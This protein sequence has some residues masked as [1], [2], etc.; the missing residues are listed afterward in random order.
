MLETVKNDKFF[1][2][3]GLMQCFRIKERPIPLM[4]ENDSYF[5]EE[6]GTTQI[7]RSNILQNKV[8]KVYAGETRAVLLDAG[9]EVNG[10]PR[11]QFNGGSGSKV[12]ITYFEKFVNATKMIKKTDAENGKII[13]LTDRI[14]LDGQNIIYEPF[15]YRTFRYIYIYI[16]K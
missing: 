13:G 9:T 5:A 8:I 7:L 6:V 11:F 14:I 12:N 10:Y 3:V 2:S 16:Y 4:Y 15:W 1:E